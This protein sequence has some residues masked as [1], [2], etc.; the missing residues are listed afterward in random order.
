MQHLEDEDP[1]HCWQFLVAISITKIKH[2]TSNWIA[3]LYVYKTRSLNM[4]H[5]NN[6]NK[7][8]VP[9][10][11]WLDMTSL[12]TSHGFRN[13]YYSTS[14]FRYFML[15]HTNISYFKRQLKI[16]IAIWHYVHLFLISMNVSFRK[17]AQLNVFCGCFLISIL[18]QIL[19]HLI[20]QT[21]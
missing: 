16:L 5:G 13:D 10:L 9:T 12:L 19:L 11:A 18:S 6:D 21:V 1:F 2:V 17:I 15:F 3:F 7:S 4:I 8:H 14:C 20:Y